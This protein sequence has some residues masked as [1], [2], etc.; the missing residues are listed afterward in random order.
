MLVKVSNARFE[1]LQ[2]LAAGDKGTLHPG[3]LMS[4]GLDINLR[5]LHGC[6]LQYR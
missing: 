1:Y 4:L 3:F 6:D 2:L 5:P